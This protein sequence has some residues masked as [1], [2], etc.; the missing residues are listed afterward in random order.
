MIAKTDKKK[1]IGAVCLGFAVLM[2]GM[3]LMGGAV[4]PLADSEMFQ[5]AMTSFGNSP[6][7]PL[8][9]IL[10]GTAVAGLLLLL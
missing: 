6:I 4:K 8:I 1:H 10:I 3:E 7:A 5:N 9:G 2:T